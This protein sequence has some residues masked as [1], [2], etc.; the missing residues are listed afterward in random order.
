MTDAE[1]LLGY[2]VFCNVLK[3]KLKMRKMIRDIR[4]IE[5]LKRLN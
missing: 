3:R 2:L 1:F 4:K 5:Q